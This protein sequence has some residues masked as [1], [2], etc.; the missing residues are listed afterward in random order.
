MK[1]IFIL[2]DSLNRRYLPLYNPAA[3]TITPNIDR[4]ADRSMVFDSHWC[5]SAPCMPARRDILT[6]RLNFLERPWGGIEPFDHVLPTLLRS[7]NVYTHMETDHFHYSECGGEN[8]WAQFTSWHLHR[9]AEHDTIHWG[10]DASGIPH[11]A[12]PEGFAGIYSPSYQATRALYDGE[13]EKFSTPRTFQSAADWLERNADA[14]NF[15]LWVEGFDPH[16]PFDVPDEFLRL[17]GAEAAGGAEDP[18]WPDYEPDHYTEAQRRR[19]R[20]RYQALTTMTDHY[21]GKLLDVL[22][23]HGLWEDTLVVFTTDHGYMLGEHGYWAKNYMPDYNEVYHIPLLIA[24]PGTAPGRCG[25]VTQNIDLFP[26]FL[27]WFGVDPSLCRNPIHG[28]DLRPLLDGTAERV[29]DTALFGTYAKSVCLTDG[30]YVYVREPRDPAVNQPL[31]LYGSTMTLL[32]EYIGYD[33]MSRGEIDRIGFAKLPW[34]NYPVYRVPAEA[35]HWKNASQRFDHINRYAGQSR[36]YDL[37][38]DYAQ[39]HP[40]GNPALEAAYAAKLRTAMAAHDSPAEQYE[41]LGL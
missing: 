14:D 16:E 22:D 27:N 38:T 25:A 2:S 10:P 21:L 3:G 20:T 24:A 15:L 5:G 26:T 32:N 30:R 40:L 19:F 13:K 4:L 33:T 1:A 36:L 9:G 23:R 41:R 39:E 12:T 29:R 34:T 8:Y 35:V 7:R 17:Y 11:P 18:Y 31:Y 6:G 28:R 37:K